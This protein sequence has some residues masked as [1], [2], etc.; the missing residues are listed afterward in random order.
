MPPVVLLNKPMSLLVGPVNTVSKDPLHRPEHQ[1]SC[2][3]CAS[4]ASSWS[5]VACLSLMCMGERPESGKSSSMDT[6][7]NLQEQPG[8]VKTFYIRCYRHF[9]TLFPFWHGAGVP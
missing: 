3:D 8:F 1:Q 9:I 2:K 5:M 7:L 6:F 4:G